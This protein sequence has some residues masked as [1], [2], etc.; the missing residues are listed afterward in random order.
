MFEGCEGPLL[1]KSCIYNESRVEIQSTL[2]CCV[3]IGLIVGGSFA[4]FKIL[5]LSQPCVQAETSG[6]VS[7]VK[8][9]LR[10]A[11]SERVSDSRLSAVVVVVDKCR[12]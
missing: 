3:F 6:H 2:C 10:C 7:I 4:K 1:Y 9:G 5:I 11:F 12:G 8:L